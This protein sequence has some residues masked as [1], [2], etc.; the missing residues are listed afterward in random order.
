MQ[1]NL[2]T[3]DQSEDTKSAFEKAI[4]FIE[5]DLDIE[6]KEIHLPKLKSIIQ[7]WT[8]GMAEGQKPTDFADLL[9]TE[10]KQFNIGLEVAKSVLGFQ[11]THTLPAIALALVERFA[12]DP[13]RH[14][15]MG[16]KLKQ[17]LKIILGEPV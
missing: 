3:S 1:G 13:T 2:L 11:K 14:I 4:K 16:E 12:K 9:S 10:K 15:Q 5:K 17:E 7:I 8:A 6:M